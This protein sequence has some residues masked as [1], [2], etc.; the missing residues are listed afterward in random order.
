MSKI[1]PIQ[2]FKYVYVLVW[3][4]VMFLFELDKSILNKSMTVSMDFIYKDSDKDLT[5]WTELFPFD[6]P[7]FLKWFDHYL[8]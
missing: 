7:E 3:A 2:A 1:P 6:V 5:S 8:Y 4:S